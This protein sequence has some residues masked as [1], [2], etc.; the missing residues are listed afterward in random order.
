MAAA[1]SQR[2]TRANFSTPGAVSISSTK[3]PL[4]QIDKDQSRRFSSHEAETPIWGVPTC[5]PGQTK[6]PHCFPAF[7]N[8]GHGQPS[9]ARSLFFTDRALAERYLAEGRSGNMAWAHRRGVELTERPTLLEV[10]CLRERIGL[11]A[12]MAGPTTIVL[13]PIWASGRR[14][15]RGEQTITAHSNDRRDIR[16]HAKKCHQ[17]LAPVGCVVRS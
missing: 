16:G 9:S 5:V 7:L 11:L 14:C 8:L 2:L 3:Q 1:E 12:R 13:N 4:Q 15:V 17:L 10:E 6:L